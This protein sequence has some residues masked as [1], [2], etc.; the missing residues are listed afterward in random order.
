MEVRGAAGMG[1]DGMRGR[2]ILSLGSK[3]KKVLAEDMVPVSGS[4]FWFWFFRL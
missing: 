3:S 2:D 1:W 4:W